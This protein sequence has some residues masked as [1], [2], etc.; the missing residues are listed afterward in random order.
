MQKNKKKNRN[1]LN[2]FLYKNNKYYDLFTCFKSK[3][4][5][6][7]NTFFF[8]SK[9]FKKNIY[10][11][12]YLNKKN[13]E[14]IIFFDKR[15][16]NYLDDQRK[17]FNTCFFYSNFNYKH[18]LM[19]K[20]IILIFKYFIYINKKG[21]INIII[22]N[23]KK[24]KVKKNILKIK[25]IKIYFLKYIKNKKNKNF[26]YKNSDEFSINKKKY[27]NIYCFIKKKIKIGKIMQIQI[28]KS[29]IYKTNILI[30]FFF[31]FLSDKNN[32]N[33]KI[34][35]NNIKNSILCFSPEILAIKKNKKINMFPIAGTSNRGNNIILDIIEEYK[36]KNDNKEIS[37]HLMLID[38]TRN[39]LNKISNC[40]KTIVTKKFFTKK[41]NDIQ[42][43][44]SVIKTFIKKKKIINILS[45]IT[46]AGT[47]SGNPK[48]KSIYYIKKIEKKRKFYGGTIGL[49]NGLNFFK[50]I[51]IIRSI[52]IKK[53]YFFLRSASGIVLNSNIK[54]EWSEL[55]KKLKIFLYKK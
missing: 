2:F 36:M 13:K 37:E 32:Y 17:I 35:Y 1:S 25:K 16:R 50:L 33:N 11:S 18:D 4:K 20:F 51:I 52:M 34:F 39:D 19:N 7:S 26:F 27:K 40:Y 55:N 42:H 46:P 21:L 45:S 30:N 47:L 29:K 9:I 15:N 41:F 6:N 14:K 3:K 22:R 5:V 24:I 38:L 48:K 12:F 43:I 23:I 28:G 10:Y 31:K 53:K 49:F 8:F 54:N 44:V